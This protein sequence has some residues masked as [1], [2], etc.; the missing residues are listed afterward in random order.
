MMLGLHHDALNYYDKAIELQPENNIIKRNKEAALHIKLDATID[1]I[2][3]EDDNN[4]A[5]AIDTGKSPI[6]ISTIGHWINISR[7]NK[8]DITMTIETTDDKGE[9]LSK[10]LFTGKIHKNNALIKPLW[11]KP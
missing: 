2:V 4:L 10:T 1:D 8:G 9:T 11:E 5:I 7:S 3:V 6:P